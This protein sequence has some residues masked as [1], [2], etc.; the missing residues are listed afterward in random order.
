[1]TPA[2][3]T[4]VRRFRTPRNAR[5]YASTSPAPTSQ[6]GDAQFH[7]VPICCQ[8]FIADTQDK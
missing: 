4:Q 8:A 6:T 5:R 2:I 1:M 3:K 7:S